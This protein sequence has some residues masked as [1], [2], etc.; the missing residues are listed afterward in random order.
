MRVHRWD[1]IEREKMTPDI[2]RR[3]VHSA[4]M[5][6]A[7]L[8]LRQGAVV[9]RHSHDNEQISHVLSGRL[10]FEFDDGTV[11]VAAGE[12][13]EIESNAPHRVVALEDSVAMDV[14][15]PVRGDW[16]R[17]D[18]AYLRNPEAAEPRS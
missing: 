14:F 13:M 8:D 10:L 11:E 7:L 16:L 3:F 17:G 1:S 5:T 12:M 15:A 4:R 18:D 9:P 2:E 6:T